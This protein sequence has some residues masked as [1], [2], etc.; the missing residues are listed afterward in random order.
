MGK[1]TAI[2]GKAEKI[3]TAYK[4]PGGPMMRQCKISMVRRPGERLLARAMLRGFEPRRQMSIALMIE[5]FIDDCWRIAAI[6]NF[7]ENEMEHMKVFAECEGLDSRFYRARAIFMIRDEKSSYVQREI[8]CLRGFLNAW[9]EEDG[10]NE[11]E[12][13]PK[14]CFY[15]EIPLPGPDQFAYLKMKEQPYFYQ[16]KN[17][18]SCEFPTFPVAESNV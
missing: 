8:L 15:D 16:L 9:S 5:I 4:N 17:V 1:K 12:S 2:K 18:H 6:K 10:L 14:D 13:V 3:Q 7:D 11:E